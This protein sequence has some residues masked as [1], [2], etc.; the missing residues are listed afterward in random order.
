MEHGVLSI[1]GTGTAIAVL[2][3]GLGKPPAS[4]P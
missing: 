1:I 4:C 3:L 2:A